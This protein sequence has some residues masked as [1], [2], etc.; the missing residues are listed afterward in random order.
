MAQDGF[1]SAHN[2][3]GKTRMEKFVVPPINKACGPRA[4][5]DV[6]WDCSRFDFHRSD[7][8]LDILVPIIPH[9]LEI[10]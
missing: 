7:A 4:R 5:T 10:L 3:F 1:L 6:E 9:V 2:G 8:V